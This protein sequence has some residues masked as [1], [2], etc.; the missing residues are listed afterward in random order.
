[1]KKKF[2]T[3]K[4]IKYKKKTKKYNLIGGNTEDT[5]EIMKYLTRRVLETYNFLPCEDKLHNKCT[6]GEPH[7]NYLFKLEGDNIITD[8]NA[9]YKVTT[10]LDKYQNSENPES[11]ENY[12][13]CF[14]DYHGS[15][16]MN[17]NESIKLKENVY[18]CIFG[19]HD[20]S[21]RIVDNYTKNTFNNFLKT[22]NKEQFNLICKYKAGLSNPEMDHNVFINQ[23]RNKIL[24]DCFTKSTWIYP[25]Q[26]YF[27]MS[28][29]IKGGNNHK[30]KY[31]YKY[32]GK[33]N[34]YSR[35]NNKKNINCLKDI[36]DE[37]SDSKS[38]I[39]FIDAC[40]I[41][42]Y[43][44]ISVRAESLDNDITLC[45][46]KNQCLNYAIMKKYAPIS[47]R[48][49]Q[50]IN[51][52]KKGFCGIDGGR[53]KSLFFNTYSNTDIPTYKS[54]IPNK[55]DNLHPIIP[56]LKHIYDLLISL[57]S[58]LYKNVDEHFKKFPQHLLIIMTL[59]FN[60][61]KKFL[62]KLKKDT[63]DNILY[64]SVIECIQKNKT[65]GYLFDYYH[66]KYET[67]LYNYSDN[68]NH[69]FKLC[70][71]LFDY[72]EVSNM[73]N[74]Y[75]IIDKEIKKIQ[76]TPFS[77]I[78]S[79]EDI[80][81]TNLT[82]IKSKKIVFSHFNNMY[83][84]IPFSITNKLLFINVEEIIITDNFNIANKFLIS[85]LIQFSPK[86]RKLHIDN[87]LFNLD[88]YN[89]NNNIK[90]EYIISKFNPSNQ[91]KELILKEFGGTD[92]E[93]IEFTGFN[94]IKLY[95]K[96]NVKINTMTINNTN[97]SCKE[98][99][100][101]NLTIPTLTFNT[102]SIMS[103]ELGENSDI[104]DIKT[105]IHPE[106]LILNGPEN[107]RH[108]KIFKNIKSLK[109]KNIKNRT[110]NIIIPKSV[111]ELDITD[112]ILNIENLNLS[113]IK[114]LN[115]I[116]SE[117]NT[118][119]L[120]DKIIFIKT[121]TNLRIFITDSNIDFKIFLKA[122][123]RMSNITVSATENIKKETYL[124]TKHKKNGNIKYYNIAYI[125]YYRK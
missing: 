79:L 10:Y 96:T 17:T 46:Y 81:K 71:F 110:N 36:I 67:F 85:D 75:E 90:L 31:T 47:S 34:K 68:L 86:L 98:I 109:L 52:L 41:N 24:F 50:K 1:M 44:D 82:N 53:Y 42:M 93:K 23:E 49:K 105:L 65:F 29:S 18:L 33:T 88:I 59:T 21:S 48:D 123:I 32:D 78:F 97:T 112:C 28:L 125:S 64:N 40:R 99:L 114:K 6:L 116:K 89:N 27:N 11:Y 103:L 20:T 62:V 51:E 121:E 108:L 76:N 37:K 63:G 58:Q 14:P 111:R 101:S 117:I 91:D 35:M 15:H 100:L 22:M 38:H 122:N 16:E 43:Q 70:K 74:S 119:G 4:N 80:T 45:Y 26:R 94:V 113:K 69:N 57:N 8:P 72:L 7:E 25:N 2:I 77:I 104:T 124:K 61:L 55:N 39:I 19:L 12:E 3:K 73:I 120:P 54:I 102:S 115:I 87:T 56:K 84:I 5:P 60:K 107:I 118:V 95:Y 13:I 66:T 92:E 9:Q 106:T 30:L 83:N